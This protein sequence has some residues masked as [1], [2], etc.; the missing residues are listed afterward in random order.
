MSRQ[1][2]R[3]LFDE[4]DE[5]SEP[6]GPDAPLAERMRPRTLDEYV[7]QGHLLGQGRLVSK[8]VEGGGP[9]PSLILWG[10]PGTGKTTLARLLTGGAGTRFVP[11]SA[12]LSR[13]KELREA[14]AEARDAQ[15]PGRPAGLFIDQNHRF[16]KAPQDARLPALQNGT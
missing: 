4:P 12:A 13:V 16:N 15:R 8:L 2:T 1:E 9:L 7:G 5:L 6:P 10:P 3:S 11:L 14:V